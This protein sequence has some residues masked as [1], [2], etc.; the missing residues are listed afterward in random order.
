MSERNP[1]GGDPAARPAGGVPADAR[2]WGDGQSRA[3]PR[4][5]AADDPE[6][7]APD[8]EFAAAVDAPTQPGTDG[9]GSGGLADGGGPADGADSYDPAA[10]GDEPTSDLDDQPAGS[11]PGTSAVA[12]QASPDFHAARVRHWRELSRQRRS[13]RKERPKR[14]WWIELPILIVVAFVLTFLIQTFIARVYYVPSGSMEHTLH[15]TTSGGDRILAFK[16]VYDFRGPEQGEVVVFKGPATWTPEANIPGPSSWFGKVAQALGSVVGIAPPNEKD[17]VKRVIA[18][19]GQTISC[20]DRQGRVQVDGTSLHEP[21]IFMDANRPEWAWVDGQST[22]NVNPANPTQYESFRCFGP[23]TVPAGMV[24]VMG[25]HRSDSAD[26]SY[27]C[28]GLVPSA[29]VHCQGPI[30]V[31]DVI[32]KAVFIVM[33]PS[34]WG[35]V[36]SPDIM[37]SSAAP[38]AGGTATVSSIPVLPAVVPFGLVLAGAIGARRSRRHRWRG[39]RPGVRPSSWRGRR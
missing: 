30:P 24:W 23:Y 6:P 7:A 32:G 5:A 18:V 29:N 36:G 33:P 16:L 11:A 22:C 21:Y 25:D 12:G 38:P 20:C 31:D 34:R 17:Y 14:P 9:A 13:G 35:P 15:G 10:A 8:G 26:S 3:V 27:Q 1:S 19:G 28:R 2:A 37:S 39:S 4:H